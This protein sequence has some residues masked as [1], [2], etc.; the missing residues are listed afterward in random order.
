M[1]N[2]NFDQ[3]EKFVQDNSKKGYRWD[4]WTIVKWVKNPNG[5]SMQNGSFKN[6]VWGVEYRT[7]MSDAG[8]WSIKRV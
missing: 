7:P 5:Y 4:G 2:L 6:G 8:T 3:A 1:I